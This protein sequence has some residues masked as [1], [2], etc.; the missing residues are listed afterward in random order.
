M[1]LPATAQKRTEDE[2]AFNKLAASFQLVDWH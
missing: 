2:T 1:T